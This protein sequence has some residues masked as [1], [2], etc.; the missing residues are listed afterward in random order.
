MG[1]ASFRGGARLGWV[2]ASWPFA[3]LTSAADR[4]TIT[5][6][7]RYEFTPEQVVSL[8]P[9]GSLP[10]LS[11]GIRIRH[12]RTDYPENVIFWCVGNRNS[13]LSRI[14]QSGFAPKGQAVTRIGGFAIRW[15]VVVVFVVLWNLLFMLNGPF[16]RGQTRGPGPLVFVAL[17]LVL[18]F[19][20]AMQVSVPLQRAVLRE[21]HHVGEIKAFLLL[22][23]LVSGF[24]SVAFGATL[25]AGAG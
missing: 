6:L 25:L 19:S 14:E 13:I 1:E 8:E 18:G 23:Q 7:G 5:S 16:D 9:Y 17:L 24:L 3:K 22:L 20:T 11:S 21:G 2:N 4:L 12:N 10:F 15:S